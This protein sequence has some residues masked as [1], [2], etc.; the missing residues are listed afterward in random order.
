MNVILRIK[1]YQPET[2]DASR[3]Q[4][5]EVDVEPADRLLDALMFV[6]RNIDGTLCFRKS[7]AHGVCGSDAMTISGVERLACKTLIRDVAEKAGAVVTIEPLK[8]LPVQ[9]DLMVDYTRF[10]EFYRVVKPFL[11]PVQNTASS[12][13]VQMPAERARFDDPT[14]CIL[15]ASCYASC[16]VVAEKDPDF[17]GPAA[18]MQAARFVFDSRDEGIGPRLDILDDAHGVWPCENHFQCTR[19]CPRGI[20]VTKNINMVKRQIKAFKEQSDQ[21]T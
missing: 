21:N 6:K 16:P 19:V 17:I 1:R 9:R 11:V 15:C 3:F 8:S 7:C 10:F 20:K 14:K 12:E 5:F 13:T 4:D 18:I 2:D